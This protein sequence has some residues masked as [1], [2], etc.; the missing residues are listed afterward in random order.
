M[1]N[2]YQG[3]CSTCTY[4]T[5]CILRENQT[6]PVVHCD[7]FD[8]YVPQKNSEIKAEVSKISSLKSK[9][10]KHEDE[11]SPAEG[12]CMNCENLETCTY[13]KPEGGIWH[14]QEY[15]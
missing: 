11:S 6:H 14:C 4:S 13:K 5:T 10:K 8:D 3:L 15:S 12:L 2:T 9:L 1:L 7:E